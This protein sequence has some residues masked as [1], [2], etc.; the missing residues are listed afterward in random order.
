MMCGGM[1]GVRQV[2]LSLSLSLV[3]G[4]TPMEAHFC[5]GEKRHYLKKK[6]L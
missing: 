4:Q 1:F 6:K 5:K 3:K 2:L